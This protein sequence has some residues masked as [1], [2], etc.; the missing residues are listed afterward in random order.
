VHLFGY[1][2]GGYVA[3]HLAATR[4]DLVASV[5]TL[6]TKLAWSPEVAERE[7]R[8]IDPVK[9]RSKV[10]RFA[11]VLEQRHAD[12]GGWEQVLARTGALMTAVGGA[13]AISDEMLARITA[14]VRLMVGDRDSVVTVEETLGAAR[15]LQRGDLC[16]LP[17]TPHPLEQVR[18][19]LVA[20]LIVDALRSQP[21]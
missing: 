11:E 6:G 21:S 18:L 15:R 20:S 13:P 3:L 19:P 8:Q 2:M 14:P 1:S 5:V 9:I 7:L 4:P 16:V 12:A 10:P 17:N